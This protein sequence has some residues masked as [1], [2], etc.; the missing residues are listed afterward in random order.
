MVPRCPKHPTYRSRG[1]VAIL[2]CFM[3]PIFMGIAALTID[4]G[5][6]YNT[7]ADLQRAADA[8]ALAAAAALANN[9]FASDPLGAA[10]QAAIDMVGSNPVLGRQLTIDPQTD[11]VFGRGNYDP[12]TNTYSFTPTTLLPDAVRLTVRCTEDSPNGPADLF[13]AGF[14]GKTATNITASATAAIP[15]RDIAIA[16]DLSGSLRS[17]SMLQYYLSRAVNAYD[18]WDALPGGAYEFESTWAPAEIPPDPAQ[19][20][21]PGWGYFKRL[22]FGTDPAE[23]GY[24]PLIDTGLIELLAEGHHWHDDNLETY[25]VELG[26]NYD[27]VR[28]ILHQSGV[29]EYP[30][31]VAV[32]LGLAYWNS[33]LPGGLWEQRGVPIEATGDG[34]HN[35]DGGELEW[36]EAVLADTPNESANIWLEYIDIMATGPFQRRFGIKTFVDYLIAKRVETYQT[37]ELA[38]T[39]LQ[40]LQAVKNAVSLQADML[41]QILAPDQVSLAT[42]ATE[43]IHQVDLTSTFLS[44]SN[45]LNEMTPTGSSNMGAGLERAIEELTGV[46]ARPGAR[47]VII[48]LTDGT[49]NI[50]AYGNSTEVGGRAYVHEQAHR[51]ADLG[52]QIITISIGY[53]AD[54]ALMAE[55]A[56]MGGGTHFHAEGSIEQYSAQ[57]ASIFAQIGGNQ[58]SVELIE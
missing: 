48:L 56:Q 20:A 34:N 33:G 16:A 54:Q 5:V 9:Q 51:A 27:E 52:L 12:N 43:G 11:V 39:P 30:P 24:D 32:A 10:R 40:P 47:K 3:L 15:P 28:A 22:G 1:A 55:I 58:R 29:S 4:L 35:V 19:A 42:Y 8:G 13:F 36:I 31:L 49:A 25:A 7:R 37:P 18:V 2:V 23:A 57:L 17:D 50:D 6:I 45:R 14:F 46:R 44:V 26:Y 21:G 38:N 53:G 41:E